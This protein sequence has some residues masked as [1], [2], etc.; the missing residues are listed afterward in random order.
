MALR[1]P[2][3]LRA[4]RALRALQVQQTSRVQQAQQT[5]QALFGRSWR[6]CRK[7]GGG[8]RPLSAKGCAVDH[9]GPA[10]SRAVGHD[11]SAAR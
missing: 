6:C 11:K 5:K 8:R 7:G 2:W 10:K 9:H 1:A 4:L 3:T